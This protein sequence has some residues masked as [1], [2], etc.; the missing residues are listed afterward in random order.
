MNKFV[1]RYFID[2]LGGMALGLF[3]TLIIGL[4]L[5]QIGGF[6]PGTAA[7]HFLM[8]LGN[9]ATILTGAGIAAGVAHALDS[10][11]LVLYSSLLNG[12]VGAYASRFLDGSLFQAT[13][14]MLSGPGDPLGAFIAALIGAELGS[15]VSGRTRVDIVVVPA[16]TI[17]AGSLAG[18]FLGP[19]LAQGSIALGGIIRYATELRPFFMGIV[20]SVFMGMFL[21]LPISSAAIAIILGLSGLSAGAATAGCTAQM[22]GFAV[23]SYRDNGINGLLAQGLG[24]SMLQ[25]PNIVK[26][27]KIWIPA[28]VASAITGPLATTVFGMMNLPAGAGMG[29]AGLVGPI[30]A[31]QAM[32]G[33]GMATGRVLVALALVCFIL[34]ALLS[35]GVYSLMRRRGW[36]RDGD[37]H[38]GI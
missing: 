25:M 4:I 22:I 8:G 28:I 23:I 34:P 37:M 36:I 11:R 2:A 6:F 27:W 9:L 20:I 5:K 31:W 29:T 33:A 18:V 3:S 26:N 13:G 24:T 16:I 7:G 10:P 15:R 19:P 12:L 38:L 17:L 35:F 32:T 1:K 30:L 21:T 14:V